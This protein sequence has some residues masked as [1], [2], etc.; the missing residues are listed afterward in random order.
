MN[1]ILVFIALQVVTPITATASGN[2]EKKPIVMFF[3]NGMFNL[4]SEA[5][6][7]KMALEKFIVRNND[8]YNGSIEN[9]SDIK[10]S[11][12][13]DEIFFLQM[14]QVTEQK[15][16][17]ETTNFLRY[18]SNINKAPNWFKEALNQQIKERMKE[19]VL[20]D[21]DL[22]K[23]VHDYEIVLKTKK[24][25]LVVAHS[26][27][28]LYANLAF[29]A[30][31]TK[32]IDDAG[33]LKIVSVA[34]P[35]SFVAGDRPYT[36]LESDG[37]ITPIPGSLKANVG[38]NPVGKFDHEFVRHYLGG[39]NSSPQIASQ[40]KQVVNEKEDTEVSFG[41][42]GYFSIDLQPVWKKSLE[43]LQNK[44][45]LSKYQCAVIRTIATFREEWGLNC[46][47]RNMDLMLKK[48]QGCVDQILNPDPE[49]GKSTYCPFAGG[50][51]SDALDMMN[52]DTMPNL[53]N[54]Q[55][56]EFE[57]SDFKRFFEAQDFKEALSWTNSF[58]DI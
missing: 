28:N 19:E 7:S 23:Q 38:N 31:Q 25:P 49:G 9:S 48:L 41:S 18:L 47:E 56:C 2:C 34:N 5:W 11:Y 46:T 50:I 22:R 1:K 29:E 32:N 55:E 58:K 33:T 13:S 6:K 27:G 43:L 14:L 57:A 42:I 21:K 40:I 15:G 26:Q 45:M 16:L 51:S 3:G 44:K 24:I 20:K 37:V 17:V 8:L 53:E 30:L 10:I 39:N 35:A 52:K 4:Y 12:N 54:H 36:T